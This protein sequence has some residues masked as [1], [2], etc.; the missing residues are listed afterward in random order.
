MAT[1]VQLEGMPVTRASA[2]T[3]PNSGA[4]LL[5]LGAA[6]EKASGISGKDGP[7][8]LTASLSKEKPKQTGKQSKPET[9]RADKET[10]L[11]RQ[12]EDT[13]TG[14]LTVFPITISISSNMAVG[15]LAEM[16]STEAV[17]D[18]SKTG[19]GENQSRAESIPGEC[20]ARLDG[21]CHAVPFPFQ[22]QGFAPTGAK[23]FA[24]PVR[25]EQKGQDH[26]VVVTAE[27][28]AGDHAIR[29][30]QEQTEAASAADVL[31]LRRSSVA[32]ERGNQTDDQ[33]GNQAVGPNAGATGMPPVAEGGFMVVDAV[34]ES[35]RGNISSVEIAQVS[36][37][38]MSPQFAP[39]SIPVEKGTATTQHAVAVVAPLD[40]VGSGAATAAP[41]PNKHAAQLDT[42][43][44]AGP[45]ESLPYVTPASEPG[46]S[47]VP[48]AECS[49][50]K[51]EGNIQS[52]QP[53]QF[54]AQTSSSQNQNGSGV[55]T[56]DRA[57]VPNAEQ[58]N[59]EAQR[60]NNNRTVGPTIRDGSSKD[61]WASPARNNSR[62]VKATLDAC[63]PPDSNIASHI[64]SKQDRSA[65]P[66]DD[67]DS[68]ADQS[69]KTGFESK[70]NSS[71]TGEPAPPLPSEK[72]G[73]S[74][75]SIAEVNRGA[76]PAGNPG[77]V[78]QLIASPETIGA[79]PGADGRS[80]ARE[81]G[82][83]EPQIS[84]ELA[85]PVNTFVHTARIL[86]D[87]AHTEM[88]IALRTPETGNVE[89]RTFIR[90][91]QAGAVIA[92]EKAD[93]RN[94]LLSELPSLQTNL[95]DRQVDVG[96][97]TV[98]DYSGSSAS[99]GSQTSGGGGH[100]QPAQH[101]HAVSTDSGGERH[102]NAFDE[103]HRNK[104]EA[105]LSVHA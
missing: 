44:T 19:N 45:I 36:A 43:L 81:N 78:H 48:R 75:S 38:A 97:L 47:V 32:Q 24:P 76:T 50:G 49:S 96:Q 98:S 10:K 102:W 99:T 31:I 83:T 70:K 21:E 61:G 20:K 34:P 12:A 60:Y 69:A 42:K 7:V 14:T 95:R 2:P 40:Q 27:R 104:Q 30:G 62:V 17:A 74:L 54:L 86:E 89:V 3:L 66:A 51:I 84:A 41:G 90:D 26:A 87:T 52:A 58:R 63:A 28:N 29:H 93:I 56:I 105:G 1:A 64:A 79:K 77:A 88:R 4:F 73:F 82:H 11:A 8:G 33:A 85:R 59:N 57:G 53:M 37:S 92:V 6:L 22:S 9:K 100:Q 15:K 103:T 39:T 72:Q 16:T 13:G 18:F 23:D 67:S 68:R 25:A 65:L 94:V 91:G 101:S 46:K 80:S 55:R 35:W 71:K 5:S